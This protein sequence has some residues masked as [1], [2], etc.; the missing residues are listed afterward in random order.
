MKN[1]KVSDEDINNLSSREKN[2]YISDNVVQSTLYFQKKIEKE[3]KMTTMGNFL[4]TDCPYSASSYYYRIEFQQ[5]GAP[6]VHC[7]IWL[8][9]N[10]GKAAPTFWTADE[11]EQSTD[12]DTDNDEEKMQ[13]LK[14]E[15]ILKMEKIEDIAN[16]LISTSVS[17]A[18]CD[19]HQ[20]RPNQSKCKGCFSVE[21]N[22]C[23]LWI[24]PV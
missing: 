9:D 21:N 12:E 19:K 11:N 16:M 18:L 2:K 3:L 10:N 7:L 5:R 4:S 24:I 15:Q 23:M 1:E 20:N 6:H 8:Q 13:N 22:F 17:S 14:N